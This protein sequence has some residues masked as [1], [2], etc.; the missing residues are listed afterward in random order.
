MAD[1]ASLRPRKIRRNVNEEIISP[2]EGEMPGRAEGGAKERDSK[3]QL[4][5]TGSSAFMR[6]SGVST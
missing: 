3:S 1:F 2:L 4:N 5:Q 6:M